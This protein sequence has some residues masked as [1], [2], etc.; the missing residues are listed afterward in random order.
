MKSESAKKIALRRIK[1][2]FVT[3]DALFSRE[4]YSLLSNEQKQHY[5]DRYVELARKIAMR[6][7]VSIPQ[8]YKKTFCEHCHTY[9]RHGV[10]CTVRTNKG[11]LVTYCNSC[12]K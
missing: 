5:A 7:T 4:S 10:N 12:K 11:V 3:A 9:F 2:L 8:N 6:H 1:E